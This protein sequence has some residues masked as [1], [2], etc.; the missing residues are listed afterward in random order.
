MR[1]NPF[2]SRQTACFL[3]LCGALVLTVGFLAFADDAK[4]KPKNVPKKV[5]AV[6]FDPIVKQIE[7]WTV[8]VDP[9]M[10]KGEHSRE[11]ARALGML[12]NHLQRIAILLP[13]DRLAKMRKLEIWIEHHHPTLGAMQYHPAQKWLTDRGY[14]PR[15]T[16][17]VH[18]THAAELISRKQMLKHPAVILHELAH[19]YHDQVLGFDDAGII[20]AYKKAMKE[21]LYDKALLFN[22]REVRHY[23]ATDHKEYFA[24]ATEAYFYHNDFYPFVRAELKRH[25]PAGYAEMERV[26]GK[27]N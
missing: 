8:H 21:G 4:P 19:A 16:K 3:P 15:L 13:E 12:A 1:T 10:L 14:D 5:E 7:G 22:G 23:G 26:W 11:G 25:D 24:E 27:V 20:E 18:I 9:Q 2:R 17:K 6:R